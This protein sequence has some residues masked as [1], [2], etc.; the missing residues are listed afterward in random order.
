[1]SRRPSRAGAALAAAFGLALAMSATPASAADDARIVSERRPVEQVIELTIATG[2][3]AEPTKVDVILPVGYGKRRSRDWPVTYFTAG[4]MNNHHSFRTLADGV[5][6]ARGYPSIIVSPD[7]NSGYWSDWFNAGAFGPPRYETFVVDQLIPLIEDRFRTLPGRDHRAIFGI[8]MGGYGSLMFAGRHP[9]LFAAAA[10]LS[11]AVDSSLA[12]NGAVL[13]ASSTFD[14][15]PPDAIY[16]PRST[17]EVRWRGHNPTDLADNLRGL[18]LQ[19]RTANG[20]PNPAIGEQALSADTV[21]CVVEG[22]VYMAS[23]NLHERLDELSVPH[24]W[25]DY[26]P[27]CHSVPNFEREIAD[28]LDVFERVL[29]DP[30]PRPR[31]FD[32]RSIEPRF[33]IW[34]WRVKADPAR[35]LEFLELDDAGRRGV[36]LTGSGT[37]T[38]TT[39]P[40]FRRVP[41]VEVV[42]QGESR[43]IEPDQRGRLH[44]T[45]DL[46][47]P[48]AVQ[49]YTAGATT[50]AVSRRVTF[51]VR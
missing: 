42:S 28:T 16:G 36:T 12:L 14:G 46:G 7:G 1:M 18:D 21:S 8:S 43:T 32:Y 25:T 51:R 47:S 3:F 34:G 6:L 39:R 40:M 11:G 48:N 5:G 2:A 38:L 50:A 30:P 9:D 10:S 35:A 49:Q 41:A 24:S 22:G 31:R 29:A 20:V 26:G 13:S 15:G 45:V 17:Q 4:M 19:V 33:D 44:F 37:T 27:G 23:V